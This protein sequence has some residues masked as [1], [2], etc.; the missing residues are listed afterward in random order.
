MINALSGDGAIDLDGKMLNEVV[1]EAQHP[2]FHPF[3][4]HQEPYP[5]DFTYLYPY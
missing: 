2:R 5:A 4:A 3:T 1:K